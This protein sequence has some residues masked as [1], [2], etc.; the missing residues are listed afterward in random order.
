MT[1]LGQVVVQ[2]EYGFF[3][4]FFLK[5]HGYQ[6][7]YCK[8]TKQCEGYAFRV[9]SLDLRVSTHCC[10]SHGLRVDWRTSDKGLSARHH[11]P[12]NVRYFV[13]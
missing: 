7:E 9:S 4:A 5:H 1:A 10:Y 2:R 13:T 6:E 8:G 3:E 12:S 11:F